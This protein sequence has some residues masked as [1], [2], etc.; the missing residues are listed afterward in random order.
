MKKP[1]VRT[2]M[3]RPRSCGRF[4]GSG[5]MA[6]LPLLPVGTVNLLVKRGL[7]VAALLFL[8]CVVWGNSW[9]FSVA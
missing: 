4:P 2:M 3:I 9:S 6:S 8:R 7:C 5:L 1:R